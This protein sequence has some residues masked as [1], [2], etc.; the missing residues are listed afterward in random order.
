F[1]AAMTLFFV[2]FDVVAHGNEGFPMILC[3]AFM[4]T[5]L[6]FVLV[7]YH[8][9]LSEYSELL[10]KTIN[11]R[12][13]L[14]E[15]IEKLTSANSGY[16]AFA[17]KATRRSAE[18][19][20][21][22]ITREIHDVV[23]YALINVKMLMNVGK[24]YLTKGSG[25]VISVFDSASA[26]V[27]SALQET[28]QI[29]YAQRAVSLKEPGGLSPINALVKTFRDVANIEVEINYGNIPESFDEGVDKVIYRMIQEGLVN[30][31][32]HG[33]A[34]KVSIN[35]WR[36]KGEIVVNVRDNGSGADKS[37]AGIGLAGMRERL[38]EFG[39][40]LDARKVVDGYVLDARIPIPVK[41]AEGTNGS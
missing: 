17:E 7:Y 15:A 31:F 23:G 19:E 11:D 5:S 6:A 37:E 18:N 22:R 16:Q 20:R 36:T 34:D 10:A 28:R 8:R 39:G 4:E 29:L 1:S 35:L 2:V 27:D 40:T 41:K 24:V 13:N 25:D 14:T 9:R 12:A 32:K 33:N 3:R 21:N 30:A 26:Q 38:A